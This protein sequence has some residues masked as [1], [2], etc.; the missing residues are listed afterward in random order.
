MPESRQRTHS[1]TRT[2]PQGRVH[3]A[4]EAMTRPNFISLVI[5][6]GVIGLVVIMFPMDWIRAPSVTVALDRSAFSPDGDGTQEDVA[7]FYTLSEQATVTAVVR[8]SA[9]LVI[10]TLVNE[11]P[12]IDGQH[13]ITWDGRDDSGQVVPDGLYQ[14]AVTAAATARNSEH[15][16]PV[17]VDMTPPTLQ[18][19]NLPEDITTRESSLTV[20]GSTEPNVTVWVSGDPRPLPVDARGIFSVERSLEE[21]LNPLDIRVVDVAG[22]ETLISRMITL[23]THP[24]SLTLTEPTDNNAFVS[25]NLL[26]IKGNVPPDVAVSINGRSAAVSPQGQFA[27]DLLLEEGENVLRIVAVDPVGNESVV[28]RRINLQSQGPTITISSVP[29]GLVVRDP[30]IRVSGKVDPGAQLQ[31]NGN[32]VPVDANGNFSTLVA[33][34]GGNNLIT[35]T[36]ADLAGNAS[37]VQRTVHYATASSDTGTALMPTLPSGLDNPLLWRILLGTGLVGAAFF[38]FGGLVSPVAFELTVDHPVFYPNRPNDMR[39]LIVRFHLSRGAKV[40]I[41][42]YDEFNRQVATLMEGR[43]QGAGEHFRLWDGRNTVGQILPGGSYLIQAAART[44][45]NTATSSVW[46]RLD[47]SLSALVGAS[48]AQGRDRWVDEDQIIDVE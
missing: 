15:S 19:A 4:T 11:L 21:G 34:Q 29:D 16:A 44:P 43:K 23:R 47:T 30:S 37:S 17:E 45:T 12:Q 22:N 46:V 8:N 2:H 28:E 20:E 48:T 31:V 3:N 40:D 14:L 38:L 27:L 24:P 35:V 5:A 6:L 10:R 25:S 13:A 9:G 26:T 18:L 42:V 32:T 41:T 7:A 36:A 33:L 1:R 39:M